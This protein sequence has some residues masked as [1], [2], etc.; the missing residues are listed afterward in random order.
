MAKNKRG[1]H[2]A[3]GARVRAG[4]LGLFKPRSDFTQAVE[5]LRNAGH[6]N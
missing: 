3:K 6:G 2:G 4:N 1:A 5:A